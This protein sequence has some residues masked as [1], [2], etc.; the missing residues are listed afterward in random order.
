MK[1]FVLL[2]HMDAHDKDDFVDAIRA[3]GHH[4]ILQHVD[5]V[6]KTEPTPEQ[7][8]I[9]FLKGEIANLKQCMEIGGLGSR[10]LMYLHSL[11]HE[12]CELLD[13]RNYEER[14]EEE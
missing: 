14:G 1:E 8:R 10:D 9:G 6:V 11:E 4:E 3:L 12:L 2:I 13:Y 7:K 5:E